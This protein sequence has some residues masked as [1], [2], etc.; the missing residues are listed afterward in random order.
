MVVVVLVD[1]EMLWLWLILSEVLALV[2]VVAGVIRSVSSV[3][4]CLFLP[5]ALGKSLESFKPRVSSGER[6]TIRCRFLIV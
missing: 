1:I 3:P 6:V 4:N 5:E 2:G